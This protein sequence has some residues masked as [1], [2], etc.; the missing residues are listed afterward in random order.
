MFSDKITLYKH[1]N[2]TITFRIRNK[3]R[4]VKTFENSSLI[5][6]IVNKDNRLVD[7]IELDYVEENKKYTVN[8][9]PQDIKDLYNGFDYTYFISLKNN[10][11]EVEEPLFTDHINNIKGSLEISEPYQQTYEEHFDKIVDI[12]DKKEFKTKTWAFEHI[13]SSLEDV[14]EIKLFIPEGHYYQIKI[15]YHQRKYSP[16][17]IK[18]EWQWKD[19][20]SLHDVT[21]EFV[22]PEL[23]KYDMR[24]I[25]TITNLIEPELEMKV[26]RYPSKDLTTNLPML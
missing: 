7:K 25:I 24:Y 21:G 3:D 4:V 26:T 6:N 2:N 17:N 13:I 22:L 5:L 8:I 20:I 12:T 18:E 14:K 23:Q 15:R 10:D 16:I 11:T 1:L 9:A 19:Y